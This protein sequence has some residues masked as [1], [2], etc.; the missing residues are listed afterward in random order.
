M[1]NV[2]LVTTKSKLHTSA[3]MLDITILDAYNL[4]REQICARIFRNYDKLFIILTPLKN[5]PVPE[6]A[7]H[8]NIPS[9]M[10]D[11]EFHHFILYNSNTRVSSVDGIKYYDIYKLWWLTDNLPVVKIP[12]DKFMLVNYGTTNL[13]DISDIWGYKYIELPKDELNKINAAELKYP[14]LI[15]YSYHSL[16][17]HHRVIKSKLL[18]MKKVKAKKISHSLTKKA[19]IA[20]WVGGTEYNSRFERKI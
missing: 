10:K 20:D 8:P 13:A 3:C 15:L 11:D 1:S 7:N 4:S 18:G 6:Y 17:G 2:K 14:I 16:D 5:L 9:D 12:V 19:L